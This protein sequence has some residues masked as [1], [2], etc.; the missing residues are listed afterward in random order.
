MT[1]FC[2]LIVPAM[3]RAQKKQMKPKTS[4]SHINTLFET[5][6]PSAANIM[7]NVSV[8]VDKKEDVLKYIPL[9]KEN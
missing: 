8:V 1:V 9:D 6:L 5:L 7:F 2:L 3:T 4:I